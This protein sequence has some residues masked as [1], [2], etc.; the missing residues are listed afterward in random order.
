MVYCSSC[1]FAN[2]EE[3]SFC[4][5]CGSRLSVPPRALQSDQVQPA[6]QQDAL[7]PFLQ[8][9]LVLR[10]RERVVRTLCG[11]THV[12]R[13]GNGQNLD[14]NVWGYLVISS[15]RVLFVMPSG[16]IRKSYSA[17]I[18]VEFE[19][20]KGI[21]FKDGM[22]TKRL[23][24]GHVKNGGTCSLVINDL[25]ELREGTNKPGGYA[26]PQSA[27]QELNQLVQGRLHEIEQEKQRA[28]IQ[29]VLDFSFLRAEMEKGGVV[30]QTI[31]CPSCGAGISLPSTGTSARCPYCGSV[32]YA[33]DV[34]EKM[35][36]MIGGL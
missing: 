7:P 31:R 4:G 9:T 1:G 22:L 35:K 25:R 18:E 11:G 14:L 28:R 15:Q 24:I 6:Q 36:G 13:D 20:I 5:R 3:S 30:V 23:M 19:N 26:N 34:F 12:E 17:V 8:G 27:Q 33:H 21:T 2:P 32:V 16:A 10:P 29:Y